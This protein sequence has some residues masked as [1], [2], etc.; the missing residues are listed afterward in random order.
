MIETPQDFSVIVNQVVPPG[1]TFQKMSIDYRDKKLKQDHLKNVPQTT[2][3]KNISLYNIQ[4][5]IV[6]CV[7]MGEGTFSSLYHQAK[8]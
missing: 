6:S 3:K 1:V 7:S 8:M 5:N 2:F 4:Q